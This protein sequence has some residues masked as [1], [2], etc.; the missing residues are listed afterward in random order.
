MGKALAVAAIVGLP[1]AVIAEGRAADTDSP[2]A[3]TVDTDV[4]PVV[5][6]SSEEVFPRF[7][8]AT[9]LSTQP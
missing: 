9:V 2:P 5:V 3:T 6:D 7:L 1:L 8:G 4:E